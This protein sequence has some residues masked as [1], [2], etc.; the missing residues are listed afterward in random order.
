MR[1]RIAFLLVLFFAPPM[2]AQE[3]P[4]RPSVPGRIVHYVKTH[5]EL[6]ASDALLL[7]ATSADAASSVHCQHVLG[8]GCYETNPLLG[9]H[10]SAAVTWG[11]L[12][13]LSSV[14]VA[15]DHGVTYLANH[16]PDRSYVR[17]LVWF[18]TIA[19]DVSEI[20]NVL[21]NVRIA[22]N[23]KAPLPPRIVRAR[24]AFLAAQN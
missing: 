18:G 15:G 23:G 1:I 21:G 2:L 3:S 9:T 19:V 10:P 24:A 22:E 5:K 12:M 4:V 6:L 17:H 7:A 20:P 8:K 13:G 11:Y 14:A 16:D